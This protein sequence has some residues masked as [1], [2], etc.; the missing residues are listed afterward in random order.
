MERQ[1]NPEL[2]EESFKS[3]N[4]PRCCES[5]S[6]RLW[7]GGANAECDDYRLYPTAKINQFGRE[8][9]KLASNALIHFSRVSRFVGF[10]IVTSSPSMAAPVFSFLSRN[11]AR[12]LYR[13]RRPLLSVPAFRT[14]STKH[15]KGFEPPTDDDLLE[16]RE[17]VQEFTR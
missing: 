3:K 2:L 14:V 17:R 7:R 10:C 8:R 9:E 11:S 5:S 1:E 13:C 4:P 16:L 15:P 6:A 12:T